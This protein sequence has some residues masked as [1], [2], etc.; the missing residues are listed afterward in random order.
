VFLGLGTAAAWGAGPSP[1]AAPGAAAPAATPDSAV[2]TAPSST[3]SPSADSGAV[4]RPSPDTFG[5]KAPKKDPESAPT[6]HPLYSTPYLGPFHY[7]FPVVGAASFGGS[8]GAPRSDVP[9]KWHHGDDIFASLGAPVVAVAGGTVDKIGWNRI[10]GWRL[11]LH[12]AAGNAFYYAHLSAYAPAVLHASHVKGGQVLGFIGDTGDAITTPFHLHFEV[13]PAVYRYMGEDGAV[14]P[15][16]YLYRW[17]HLQHVAIPRPALP[18]GA[19]GDQAERA[20]QQLLTVP[21]LRK[22]LHQAN[23]RAKAMAQAQAQ[24]QAEARERRLSTPTSRRPLLLGMSAPLRASARAGL[25]GSDGNARPSRG[26]STSS[27]T[28]SSTSSL[29]I[30]GLAVAGLVALIA[31]AGFARLRPL[32]RFRSWQLAPARV[33]SKSKS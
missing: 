30:A 3:P 31:V 9:G 1:D 11:W 5:S 22:A 4:T 10:G 28:N 20:F 6:S 7:V 27:D 24:A 2:P 17:R 33:R 25:R 26:A 18:V 19:V 23:V 12:D 16:S 14:D 21:S 15:T 32:R 29:E 13:H 8:Y